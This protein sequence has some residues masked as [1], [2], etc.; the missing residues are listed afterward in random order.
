M[1]ISEMFPSKYAKGEDLAGKSITLIIDRIN[2]EQ[3]H[4]QPNAPAVSKFVIYFKK[5]Q[6][7]IILSRTLAEQIAEILG[8]S[9][10]DQW[11]DGKIT[12]FPQPIKV[13]GKQRIAIRAKMPVNGTDEPP[14]TLQEDE[15]L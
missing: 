3:M 10:S 4:P 6:R 5:A 7:G 15:D 9:D 12:I 13:A 14:A 11:I 1:L 8:S 2:Q